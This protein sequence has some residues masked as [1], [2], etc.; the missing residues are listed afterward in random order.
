MR[1]GRCGRSESL[2]VCGAHRQHWRRHHERGFLLRV[3]D[4][5]F[6]DNVYDSL[7]QGGD[8]HETLRPCSAEFEPSRPMQSAACSSADGPRHERP[9]ALG[10]KGASRAR[11][12]DMVHQDDGEAAPPLIVTLMTQP[13]R[14]GW[15]M[16]L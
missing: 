12:H 10:R 5:M 15:T 2:D 4:R 6:W 16:Q 9:R 3:D 11:M 8:R 14:P 7:A 13:H 1:S